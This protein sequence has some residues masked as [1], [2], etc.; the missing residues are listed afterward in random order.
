[1]EENK[2]ILMKIRLILLLIVIFA[3]AFSQ[4]YHFDYLIKY[5]FQS[6][7][8]KE[9][10][11]ESLEFLSVVNSKDYSYQINF[12]SES[13]DTMTA[14]IIDLRNNLQHY[15]NVTNT[16]FPLSKLNFDYKYSKRIPSAKKQFEDESK[17]RFFRSEFVGKQNEGLS[18]YLIN[19]Y[20]N[21]KMKKP[22]VSAEVIFADFQDDLSFIGLQLLFDYHEIYNKVKFEKNYIVK[23]A[24]AKSENL[25]ILLSL[26]TIEPQNIDIKINP[27]QLKFQN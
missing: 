6:K 27:N 23:S 26:E 15:F 21:G 3:N 19:E 11:T 24:S 25:E 22:R 17:R 2:T 14:T 7:Q 16:T 1:M 18:R 13:K 4:E 9:K 20:A 5:K 8:K 12:R 10:Q